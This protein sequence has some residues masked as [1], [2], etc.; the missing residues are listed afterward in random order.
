MVGTKGFVAQSSRNPESLKSTPRFPSRGRAGNLT[1]ASIQSNPP[2]TFKNSLFPVLS[3][4]LEVNPWDIHS[5]CHILLFSQP[6]KHIHKSRLN[7]SGMLSSFLCVSC[8]CLIQVLII[9][10]SFYLHSHSQISQ[11]HMSQ[12]P[13]SQSQDTCEI[14]NL[15]LYQKCE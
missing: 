14:C 10:E 9:F 13:E 1:L 2:H 15:H 5:A 3:L 7:E 12:I 8:S 11:A 6:P 4:H